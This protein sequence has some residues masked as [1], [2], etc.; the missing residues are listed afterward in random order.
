MTNRSDFSGY[1]F[2]IS[3]FF[4]FP[5]FKDTHSLRLNV[6]YENQTQKGYAFV[7]SPS[8]INGFES[9]NKFKKALVGEIEYELPIIYPHI[10][11]GPI[12]NIQRIRYTSFINTA[13]V[14]GIAP[15]DNY[16]QETP[17][18]FGGELYFD[19]NFFRQTSVFNLG[20]RWSY[21][22][23]NLKPKIELLISSITF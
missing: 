14:E 22:N 1:Y 16:V 3:S 21:I 9:I 13:I 18:G 7:S 20:L 4:D 12:L 23:L 10:H 5:G 2:R 15:D 11:I 19:V 8:L 6:N 17:F